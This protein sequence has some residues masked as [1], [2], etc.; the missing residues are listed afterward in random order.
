MPSIISLSLNHLF[1]IVLLTSV[2]ENVECTLAHLPIIAL[3]SHCRITLH[4]WFHLLPPFMLVPSHRGFTCSKSVT[5]SPFYYFIFNIPLTHDSTFL[6]KSSWSCSI[7]SRCQLISN[8]SI[9][10]SNSEIHCGL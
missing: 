4:R 6:F 3:S 2:E 1:T 5:Y 7:Y 8:V 10:H 9:F